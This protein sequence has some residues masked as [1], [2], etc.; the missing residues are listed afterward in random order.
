MSGDYSK[1][2]KRRI[3]E[4]AALA[5]ERKLAR[6]LTQ[7]EGDFAQWRQG[8]IDAF[9]VSDRIHRFHDGVARE[10]WK[11]YSSGAT[12]DSQVA[13][14]IANGAIT[15]EEAGAEVVAALQPR[16]EMYRS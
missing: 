12:L 3:R 6:A 16:I 4:L 9:E 10:L 11:H 13:H 14:D 5:H 15:E 2:V 7:L 1:A 8:A